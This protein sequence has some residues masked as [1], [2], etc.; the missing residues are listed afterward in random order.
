MPRKLRDLIRDLHDAG[1]YEVKGGAKALT[2]NL[3]ILNLRGLL[4]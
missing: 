4:L 1:F 3:G 2:E